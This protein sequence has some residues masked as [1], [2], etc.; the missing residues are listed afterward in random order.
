MTGN[1]ARNSVFSRIYLTGRLSNW[2]YLT[3]D[4][5]WA[6]LDRD[7]CNTS[8]EWWKPI[9]CDKNMSDHVTNIPSQPSV[10]AD[11]RGR[12]R[13]IVSPVRRLE[14]RNGHVGFWQLTR[15]FWGDTAKHD[16]KISISQKQM[17]TSS[18]SLCAEGICRIIFT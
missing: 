5:L 4:R 8:L 6:A 12:L 14:I 3:G 7:A 10:V 17:R 18:L 2:S 13:L 11:V 16:A 9:V 15:H 1:F